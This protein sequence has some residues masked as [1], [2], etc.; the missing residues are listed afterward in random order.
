MSDKKDI[1]K[2]LFIINTLIIL[3]FTFSLLLDEKPTF[4]DSGFSTSYDSGGSSYSS[5]SSSS[6][7]SSNSSSSSYYPSS[8]SSSS[9]SSPAPAKSTEK[10]TDAIV[11]VTP[12]KPTAAPA[13]SEPQPVPQPAPWSPPERGRAACPVPP[14]PPCRHA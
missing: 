5:S 7:S 14:T 12:V 4:A 2:K 3:I 1:L 8:S 9:S 10:P 13:Q 11:E 6:S